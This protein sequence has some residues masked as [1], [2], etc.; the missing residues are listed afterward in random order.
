MGKLL[1]LE[2]ISKNYGDDPIL[3]DISFSIERGRALAIIGNSGGGKTTLLTIMGLLQ[4]PSSGRVV[5]DGQDTGGLQP[6]EYAR[7]RGQYYGFVFQRARLL[8]SL[9][10]LENVLAPAWFGRRGKNLEQRAKELLERFDLSHRLHYKPQELSLGQLRR[11]SLARALLLEPPVLLA[12]E[13]TNDLDPDLAESVADSLLEARN[14]G[15]SVVIVT[16]DPALAV[17]ADTVLRLRQGRL[18][19][20]VAGYPRT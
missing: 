3:S 15:A 1:E 14:S 20:E 5:I 17:R 6:H 7:L 10:A 13:P 16:H 8:N 12:D 2:A 11:I 18:Q 9:N 4:R 19:P